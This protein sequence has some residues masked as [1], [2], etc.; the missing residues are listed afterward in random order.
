MSLVNFRFTEL[1]LVFIYISTLILTHCIVILRLNLFSVFC[2]Q[3]MAALS[4]NEYRREYT[5]RVRSPL[6]AYSL[7]SFYRPPEVS[8]SKVRVEFLFCVHPIVFV[9]SVLEAPR[10]FS[11]VRD[12]LLLFFH[13]FLPAASSSKYIQLAWSVTCQIVQ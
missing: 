4:R 5:C 9:V 6:V 11:R 1:S 13:V 7:Q 2:N 3:V 12:C 10:L 8:G